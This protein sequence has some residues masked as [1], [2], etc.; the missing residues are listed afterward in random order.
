MFV[1]TLRCDHAC[2]YCQ[3]SRQSKELF[4]YD[5]TQEI[6]DKAIEFMFH[7]PSPM[8]KIEFQGGESLLNFEMVKYIVLK[9]EEKNEI[10]HRN[11]DFVITTNLAPLKAEHLEFC[12]AHNIYISTSLDGPKDLHNQNRPSPFCDSYEAAVNGI[13]NVLS[14]LGKDKISALMTTTKESLNY[15]R[16]IIDEYVK[17]GFQSIF[18]RTINPYGFAV[19]SGIM[20]KYTIEEWLGFY[21]EA[22]SYIIDLN[23]N[24]VPFREEYSALILKKMLTPYP[25]GYVDLQSP[26]GIGISCLVFNYDGLVYVSDEARMLAQMGDESFCIGN[27]LTDS[28]EEVMLNDNLIRPLNESMSEGVPMCADCGIQP[29]CGSDP[30]RHYA[31][32]GD[33]VG[34]KPTSE[35]CKKH[36]GIIRHLVHLLEDDRRAASIL[37]SWV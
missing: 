24:Q 35:F 4:E 30:V 11:L 21:K 25:I 12:K 14:T 3:V 2:T 33:T 26:A 1:T 20:K 31:V 37:R 18:L 28:Y 19:K 29:Y 17:H 27:L 32:Q 22:L 16:E 23:Y 10:E 9:S 34:N 8:I 13:Q 15:P 36:M 7:S 5:M 6:A